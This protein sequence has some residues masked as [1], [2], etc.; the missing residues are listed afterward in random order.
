MHPRFGV[1]IVHRRRVMESRL[2]VIF[3]ENCK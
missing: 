2:I 1:K 3:A